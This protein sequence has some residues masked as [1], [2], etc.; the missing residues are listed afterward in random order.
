MKSNLKKIKDCKVK[1]FVEVEAKL[2]EDR[3]QEVLRDLQKAAQLPGFREGKAP[4]D[5]IE[6]KFSKEAEE[7]V[8]KSLI[9]EAYHQS[10]ATHKV[11][12]ATLPSIS[13]I[14]LQR[15]KGLTFSAEFEKEPEFSLRNYKGIKIKKFS[16]EVSEEEV[17]KGMSSLLDS[18]GELVPILESRAVQKGDFIITDIEVWQ[19]GQYVPGRKGTLLFVE[20]NE[21]DDFYEKVVG[22]QIEEV[23]EISVPLSESEKK[24]GP[25]GRKPSY[26]IWIRAIQEK[27]PPLLDD[28][29]AKGFG[30]GSLQ[31]LRE[32]VRKDIGTYKRTDSYEKMK[33][34]IFQKLL[35]L[36]SFEIPEGLVQKQKERLVE[37]ARRQYEKVGIPARQFDER[38]G[39]IEEESS[40]K[41]KEQVKLYFILQRVAEQEGI[42]IDEMELE[43]KLVS[44]AEESKRTMDEIRHVFEEDLRESARE[45]KTTEFLLA[46]A[47]LEE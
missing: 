22:A 28:E 32:A 41:A 7:E 20:P 25:A 10:I 30:K 3:F 8:L 12:P 44:L 35:L 13:E 5:M 4:F 45:A 24:E 31:E 21:R 36:A 38:K 19:D 40:L 14:K 42:E 37:Q 1:L 15:G 9:P 23:R 17:E 27:K 39:K 2:V 26:K 34:E 46:N 18:K 16:V 11:S 29:F 33:E 43:Q 47:K 6:K